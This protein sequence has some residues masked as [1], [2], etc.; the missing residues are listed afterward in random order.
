MILTVTAKKAAIWVES[1]EVKG[2][3]FSC[4]RNFDI[5]Y[6]AVFM[7]MPKMTPRADKNCNKID[8]KYDCSKLF[9]S[10]NDIEKHT[11][12]KLNTEN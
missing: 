7:E 12:S 8:L 6:D 5:F 11:K 1:L 2:M 4:V 9:H 10:F 3:S